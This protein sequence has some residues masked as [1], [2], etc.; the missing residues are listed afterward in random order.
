MLPANN[1]LKLLSSHQPSKLRVL[2]SPVPQSHSSSEP[3]L[4]FGPICLFSIA[5]HQIVSCVYCK[6]LTQLL[7]HTRPI[8]YLPMSG[9]HFTVKIIDGDA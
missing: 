3:I 8:G 1:L 7:L 9:D 5:S 6:S 2:R 4:L